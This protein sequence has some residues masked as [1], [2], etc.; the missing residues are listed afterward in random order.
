MQVTWD[1]TH[2]EPRFVALGTTLA[3]YALVIVYAYAGEE[4]VR[5]IS[6]RP[7]SRAERRRY[8]NEPR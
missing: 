5:L 1:P 8:A 3:G 2:A 7:A 4:D 6:A